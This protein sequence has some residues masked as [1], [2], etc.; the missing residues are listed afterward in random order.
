MGTDEHEWDMRFRTRMAEL[1]KA[2]GM[3][4]TDLAR[5]L[6]DFPGVKLG[7]QQTIARIEA[8]DRPV[9]LGEAPF[10][11]R[12]L[13]TT[14]QAMV[15]AEGSEEDLALSLGILYDEIDGLGYELMNVESAFRDA[16]LAAKALFQQAHNQEAGLD[17]AIVGGSV[18]AAYIA[19]A[20]TG[21]EAVAQAW[22]NLQDA[23]RAA[24]ASREP[25]LKGLD[26]G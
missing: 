25:R 11:A 18:L 2:K 1:R 24:Q 6:Q 7:H 5:E 22:A 12:V 4:Q 26:G 3:T 13:T 8:G 15:A 19:E 9:R 16:E 10:I 21:F 17:E 20:L 14:V 23:V